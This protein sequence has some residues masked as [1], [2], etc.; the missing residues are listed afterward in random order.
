MALPRARWRARGPDEGRDAEALDPGVATVREF[1]P[2]EPAAGEHMWRSRT[3]ERTLE[4]KWDEEQEM[5]LAHE[6]AKY[7]MLLFSA[8]PDGKARDALRHAAAAL[9]RCYGPEFEDVRE[10]RRLEAMCRTRTAQ[11]T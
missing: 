5:P 2:A 3:L 6:E 4:P 1:R 8:E 11:R 9:E 7:A 10:L